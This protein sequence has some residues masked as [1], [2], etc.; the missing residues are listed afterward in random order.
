M[1][2][3]LHFTVIR[4]DN[5]KWYGRYQKAVAMVREGSKVESLIVL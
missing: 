2:L 4:E 1:T 5:D 3:T